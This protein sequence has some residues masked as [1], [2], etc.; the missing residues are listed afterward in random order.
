MEMGSLDGWV[1][2]VLSGIAILIGIVL[3]VSG[4]S[5]RPGSLAEAG[6]WSLEHTSDRFQDALMSVL[7]EWDDLRSRR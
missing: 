2:S 6:S 7:R 3:A 1:S 5:W 4:M